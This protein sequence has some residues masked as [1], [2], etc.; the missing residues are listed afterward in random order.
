MGGERNKLVVLTSKFA[1]GGLPIEPL[2]LCIL[3]FQAGSSG[4]ESDGFG[5]SGLARALSSQLDF[6]GLHR[7]ASIVFVGLAGKA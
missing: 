2:A 4:L 6:V 3:D 5:D 7:R 1:G